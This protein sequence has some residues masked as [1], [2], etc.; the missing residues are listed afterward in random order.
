MSGATFFRSWARL[1]GG[2]PARLIALV[3]LLAAGFIAAG[4]TDPA[5]AQAIANQLM[6][7]AKAAPPGAQMLVESDQLVYDYDNETVSAVG[8]VKIYYNGYTLE[9]EKVTYIESSN[10]LIATGRVKLVDP[11][12]T[13][14][15][16]DDLDITDDFR[17]GF[18]Q[19]LRVDA[20]DK[21]HFAAES[22][23][24]TAGERTEFTRGVYTACE[25]CKDKP[26]RPPLWQVQAA[27]IV[28]DQKEKMI[29]FHNARMEIFG[30]PIAW[31]PYFAAP[32]PTVKRKSG[33]LAPGFGYSEPLGFSATLPYFWA[34]APNYDVT[35]SPTYYARQGFMGEV[36]WRHRLASGTY[37][38]TMAGINQNDPS[39]FIIRNANGTQTSGFYSQEEF[40]GGLRTTGE[41][42]I[43]QYWTWGWDGTLTTDRTFTRNYDVLTADTSETISNVHLTG[44][45]D[46]NYFD[47]RAEHFQILAD[48][49]N[50]IFEQERQAIVYPVLDHNY[51]FSNPVFGGELSINS[52]ITNLSRGEND[53]FTLVGT[54]YYHGLAGTFT[55]ASSGV[56][57]KKESVLPFG[58]L[59]KTFASVRGDAYFLDPTAAPPGFT[60]DADAY[61][62]MPAVGA[63]W[64]WPFLMAAGST[65]HV[66]EPIAQ[67]IVRPNETMIGQLPNEDAQSLVFDDTVLFDVDKFSGYDRIEGGTRLNAGLRYTGNFSDY[68]A[69]NA[70]FGQSYHLAGLNSFATPDLADT[71]AF[72]GLETNIS[73]Y[74]G[75]VAVDFGSDARIAA[76]GRFDEKDFAVNRAEI[77]ATKV[78]GPVT[79]S[80][81]YIY[82][83]KDLQPDDGDDSSIEETQGVNASASVRVFDNWRV[84]GALSYNLT[85][86]AIAS[87]SLGLAYDDECLSLS[88]AYSEAYGTDIPTRKLA[89]YINFRTLGD[90]NINADV[91][92][93]ASSN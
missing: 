55:R 25:P 83:R 57:W 4:F 20:A 93:L 28:H 24:R 46:R 13:A 39:A 16:A 8:N 36:E 88:I 33:V 44:L 53:P 71:G 73:D 6:R 75:S 79:M 7:G 22:A 91:T 92:S 54:T 21:T 1:I 64:R 15:Y 43:N 11:T 78:T 2:S 51:I 67:I 72:S 27:K 10:R 45:R 3:V 23:T 70:L 40:R 62:F 89:F 90:T 87:N 29:Y 42:A 80:A 77:E 35:F 59:L 9:A 63:E 5:A 38:F 32:D 49:L 52:N 37:S 14:M 50:P 41:F 60:T 58:Q 48:S 31:M 34:L 74:V 66:I 17:D 84:F 61:R 82:L 56:E 65:T 68:V 12:G 86:A 30:A 81:A 26:D 69:V 19:S 18:I 76:R 47:A 85:G